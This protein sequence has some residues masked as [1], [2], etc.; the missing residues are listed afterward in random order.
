M[1]RFHDGTWDAG[2]RSAA[3][4]VDPSPDLLLSPVNGPARSVRQ[5]LTTFHLVFVAVD[6]FA[7]QSRWIVPTAAR[8][9]SNFDQADC[10]VAWLVTGTPDECRVLLGEWADK[11]LTFSDPDLTAV[12]GF[13]LE[14][15]PALVHLGID[16]T[17]VGASEG[18]EPLAWRQIMANL[19]RTMA[20]LP[21]NIPGPGDPGPF[22]GAPV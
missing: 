6:P 5:W 16:G 10:R 17:V 12:K 19:A 3:V 8:I 13:G 15:L 14:R 11:I 7:R 21:P 20:W 9:L 1:S 4:A 18:W 22:A 2:V